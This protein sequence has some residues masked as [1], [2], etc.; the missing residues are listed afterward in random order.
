MKQNDSVF[1]RYIYLVTLFLITLTGF[2]A[3]PI[4]KR[5]YIA[6]IPGFGWLDKF[7]VTHYM[8]YFMAII[9][10]GLIFYAF[11]RNVVLEKMKVSLSGYIRGIMFSIITISGL[12]LVIKNLNC[13]YF[14][15]NIVIILDLIHVSSVMMFLIFALICLIFKLKWKK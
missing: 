4:F 2:G 6:D 10:I 14:S 7:Y 15:P 12:F 13:C 9:F 11:V 1:F 8:H 5:Y 3:M